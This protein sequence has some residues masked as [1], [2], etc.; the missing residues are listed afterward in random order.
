MKTL[1]ISFIVISSFYG[2]E[3]KNDVEI[4]P[5]YD[6]IYLSADNLDKEPQLIEGDENKLDG[7][8]Q[9][10]MDKKVQNK[11]NLEY[12]LL[13][14]ES[15]KVEKLLPVRTEGIDYSNL[16]ASEISSWKFEPAVKNGKSVKSQ[17]TWELILPAE[18]EIDASK[19]EVSADSMP[20]PV[21]G[22]K[23]L[24][25]NIIYPEKAKQNGTEGKVIVQVFI[26]ETGKVVKTDVLKSAGDDLDKAAMNALQRTMFTPGKVAGK[27]VKVRIVVPIVFKLS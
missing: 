13:I 12:K 26:D 4:I 20:S 24:Q 8:I 18:R 5:A 10:E 16:I 9:K 6:S 17:Y 1:L 22:M 7:I 15:G 2:C 23:T 19:F 21:G 27:P 11:I 25:Q 14:N 3:K